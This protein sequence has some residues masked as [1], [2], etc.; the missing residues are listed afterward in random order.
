LPLFNLKILFF[1]SGFK[2]ISNNVDLCNDVRKCLQN[3]PKTLTF[4]WKFLFNASYTFEP[5][6]PF[7]GI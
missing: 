3:L 2:N 4:E 1:E 6:I 5:I 7:R